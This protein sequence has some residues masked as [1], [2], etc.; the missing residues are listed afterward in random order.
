M[1][2][3]E[4]ERTA[5]RVH[6][7]PRAPAEVVLRVNGQD[8]PAARRAARHAA[9]C[10]ARAPRP[11]RHQEGLR[12]RPVRRLHGAYRRPARARLPDAGRHARRATRSRPSRAWPARRRA[13]PVQQAFLDHDAFQCG[14]C[15]PGQIMSAVACMREGHAGS[16][17]EI[18]EYMSGNL[19]R[20]GA[21]PNI[22]AAD[23]A[24]RPQMRRPEPM[25][26][27]A[28]ERAATRGD[29]VTAAAARR[30][31]AG[32]RHSGR[33]HDAD[34][35]DEARRDAPGAAG[36]HHRPAQAAPR[37]SGRATAACGSA[38]SPA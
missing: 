9:R 25:R 13:A 33:R 2:V 4:L 29:A 3:Q 30:G 10:V 8:A 38:R 31:S 35:P 12:P 20:C 34:R 22:V 19:C 15:T 32:A 27:F 23:P 37:S 14:Y 18:R 6:D 17:D 1:T 16:D 21:Y 5:A 11:D 24:A 7:D 28:Y 36:R 26:P